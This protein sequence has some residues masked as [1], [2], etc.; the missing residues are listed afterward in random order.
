M[1]KIPDMIYAPMLFALLMAAT[2]QRRTMD[3]YER[4]IEKSRQIFF[5]QQQHLSLS[6]NAGE[7]GDRDVMCPFMKGH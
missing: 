2:A 5:L 1:Q 4:K 7:H 3:F 6:H